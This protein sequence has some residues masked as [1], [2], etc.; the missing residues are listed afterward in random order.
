MKKIDFN[1]LK[2]ANPEKI[3]CF[4]NHVSQ[5]EIEA[6]IKLGAKTLSDIQR[7]TGACTGNQCEELNPSGKCCSGDINQ[8]LK[9]G[10]SELFK[11]RYEK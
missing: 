8:L 1:D 4:C 3:I 2:V 11:P 9:K 10:G 5:H 6:S 7:S